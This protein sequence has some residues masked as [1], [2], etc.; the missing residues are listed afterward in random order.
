MNSSMTVAQAERSAQ[1]ASFKDAIVAQEALQG[2]LRQ[3]I[4]SLKARSAHA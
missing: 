3:A 2:K 4:Q 1:H